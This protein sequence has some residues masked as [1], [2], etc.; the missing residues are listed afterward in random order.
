MSHRTIR[1]FRIFGTRIPSLRTGAAL[2]A[3]LVVVGALLATAVPSM[4]QAD[5]PGPAFRAIETAWQ[6]G[7][8]EALARQVQLDG[9]NV[10]LGS[11]DGRRTEYSPSQAV[12]F[13]E[14]LL[15][16]RRTVDFRFTQL[17]DT[18]GGER[19]HGM[20]VWRYAAP[21]R[22]GDQEMRLVFLLTRRDDVW[23]ISELNQIPVR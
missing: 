2:A 9:M 19:A 21:G 17:Q 23:R 3:G 20:A 5:G 22:A 15:E 10:S 13:F 18:P 16:S 7:D 4:A 1:T 8:T 14:G 6:N 11:S 12:Y